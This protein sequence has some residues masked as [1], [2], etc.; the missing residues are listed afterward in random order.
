MSPADRLLLASCRVRELPLR[1]LCGGADLERSRVV[2]DILKS[3]LQQLERTLR[4]APPRVRSGGEQRR[5]IQLTIMV[6]LRGGPLQPISS[7][8]QV[9]EPRRA[10]YGTHRESYFGVRLILVR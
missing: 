10:S 1:R 7:L 9:T 8:C 4:V 3:L 6:V 2:V 5:Q